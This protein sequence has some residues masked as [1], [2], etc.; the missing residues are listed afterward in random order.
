MAKVFS[1]VVSYSYSP[2]FQRSCHKNPKSA[3]VYSG[4]SLLCLISSVQ[5][6]KITSLWAQSYVHMYKDM[7]KRRKTCHQGLSESL[8]V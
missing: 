7:S 5:N 1:I 8:T 2:F 6:M 3:P 4:L